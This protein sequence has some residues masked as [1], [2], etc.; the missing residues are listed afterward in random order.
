L[1]DRVGSRDR[2][3]V[4]CA[5]AEAEAVP[6]CLLGS[7]VEPFDSLLKIVS[8]VKAKEDVQSAVK[9]TRAVV[10]SRLVELRHVRV[11]FG[12]KAELESGHAEFD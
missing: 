6:C 9:L 7:R 12:L 2:L 10:F 3:S 4:P 11:R 8:R 5:V 1:I